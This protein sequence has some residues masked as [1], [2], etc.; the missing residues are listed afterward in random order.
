[1][2]LSKEIRWIPLADITQRLR[3]KC[4]DA[5]AVVSGIDINKSFIETR[6]NL[7]DTDISQYYVVPPQ[8]FACN[9]MHIGRDEKIPIAF[10]NSNRNKVVTSAYYVFTIQ[11]EKR[12]TFLPEYVNIF[13]HLGEFD[14]RAWFITDSSVRGNLK[15]NRFLDI[16]IPVP[17][18]NGE[19]DIER[20]QEIVNIWQGLRRLKEE[21]EAIAQPLLD[22]LQAKIDELKHSAPM[23]RMGRF[24]KQR[25]EKYDGNNKL[26]IRGVSREGFIFPKQKEADLSKYNVFY[27]ND[28]V[29]NPARMEVNSIALNIEYD[30]GICSSLYEIFEI[31]D[32]SIYPEYLNI[33]IKRDE[34]ARHCEYLGWGSAREYCRVADI[35]QIEVPIPD[36]QTQLALV[37]I[38]R[39]ARRAKEIA[40]EATQQLKSIC[41]VLMQ[42]IIHS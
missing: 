15:E 10:N 2:T 32:T 28:F 36:E 18:K 34:F 40:E 31:T 41:P 14:R 37:E 5:D 25:R 24:I 23:V 11:P 17:Y 29:F 20:Q 16:K 42:H 8:Y 26:P 4:G 12:A 21:N 9:L 7:S 3:Q 1:M 39:C 22:I 33:F 19:P 13:F 30:K 6:A 35:S 27:K 38:S